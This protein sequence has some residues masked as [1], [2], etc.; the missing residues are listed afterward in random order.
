MIVCMGKASSMISN[1]DIFNTNGHLSEEGIAL[2]VE[3]LEQD[4]VSRLPEAAQDHMED[5]PACREAVL[6]VRQLTREI[7][8]DE[9]E[10]SL[11]EDQK[12]GIWVTLF[13]K[14]SFAMKAAAGAL[15]LVATTVTLLMLLNPRQDA[16][17][18][19]ALNFEPYP[20]VI[21]V[22]GESSSAGSDRLVTSAGLNFYQAGR[23]DSACRVFMQFARHHRMNDTIQFYLANSMLAM[24]ADPDTAIMLLSRLQRSNS[25]FQRPSAWYLSLALLKKNDIAMARHHLMR[26]ASDSGFYSKKALKL[27]KEIE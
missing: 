11:K 12:P 27:L 3:A 4:T 21:S 17:N 6:S 18:L 15:I 5:C 10:E 19:F 22:K 16:Q 26:L 23:Y 9:Q 14:P 25:V 13:I 1:L 8:M 20:D 7:R 24:D 2:W